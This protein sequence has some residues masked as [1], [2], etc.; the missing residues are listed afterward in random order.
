MDNLISKIR[1]SQ[2]CIEASPNSIADCD[3]RFLKNPDKI[4]DEYKMETVNIKNNLAKKFKSDN[5]VYEDSELAEISD[6]IFYGDIGQRVVGF[7]FK[8]P[9]HHPLRQEYGLHFIDAEY[10]GEYSYA[11]FTWKNLIKSNFPKSWEDLWQEHDYLSYVK[12]GF[13]A[14]MQ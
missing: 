14:L 5:A 11:V 10:E 1:P 2:I 7:E 3:S 4:L 12:K 6:L 13:K 9:I 8:S